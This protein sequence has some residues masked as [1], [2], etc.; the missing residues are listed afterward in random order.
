MKHLI[1]VVV[2]PVIVLAVALEDKAACG[3][4]HE[5]LLHILSSIVDSKIE[6]LGAVI[7]GLVR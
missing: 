7:G 5:V 1:Q 6:K 3:V 2:D 4:R